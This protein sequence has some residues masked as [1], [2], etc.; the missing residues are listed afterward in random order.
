MNIYI[1]VSDG[2]K[3]V[4]LQLRCAEDNN[5]EFGMVPGKSKFAFCKVCQKIKNLNPAKGEVAVHAL[6]R[7]RR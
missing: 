4:N 3:K 2:E 7:Q 6:P 5:Q 1:E